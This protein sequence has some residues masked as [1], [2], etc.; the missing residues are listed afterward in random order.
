M[1][2]GYSTTLLGALAASASAHTWVEQL[3]VIAPNG[4]MVGE[5][6]F[7]RGNVRRDTPGFG[8]PA[9]V[10]LIPGNGRTINQILD[11]D[12]ICKDSQ[13]KQVQTNNSPR[14]KAAPGSNVALRYQE[15]GHV[16]LPQG[17]PGKPENRGTVFVYGTTQPKEDDTFLSIH[18]QWNAEGTGGDGRG[19]LLSTRDFD[20]SQCYQVNGGAISVQ[21]QK[22]FAHAATP[23]MGADLWCQQ[24]IQLPASA[25]S[26]KPYTLYWVWDWPTLP[27]TEGFPEG[28]QEI[29]TTCMDIDITAG[30]LGGNGA[31]DNAQKKAAGAVAFVKGQDLANA[32]VAAQVADIAN[33]TAV[34]GDAIPFLGAAASSPGV[35]PTDNSGK[36]SSSLSAP[37]PPPPAPPTPAP[38][39]P[40]APALV[41]SASSQ[42]PPPAPLVSVSKTC[43]QTTG[44][45]SFATETQGVPTSTPA[46][47]QPA[48]QS[49][50]TNRPGRPG[51]DD[52]D[53]AGRP[54]GQQTGRRTATRRLRPDVS[55]ATGAPT[56][57]APSQPVTTDSAGQSAVPDVPGNTGTAI[58]SFQGETT[59]VPISFGASPATAVSSGSAVTGASSSSKSVSDA[60]DDAASTVTQAQT[61]VQTVTQ[62]KMQTMVQSAP[63]KRAV[64]DLP[65]PSI[66]PR[67]AC[68]SDQVNSKTE[69]IYQ[70]RGRAPFYIVPG[71][72]KS[73]SVLRPAKALKP[74]ATSC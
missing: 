33:P 26:G 61:V 24:D 35:A 21:R 56:N 8:D 47:S 45:T 18:R 34:V 38:S 37:P 66:R 68:S 64:T 57:A 58:Q 22:T 1:K 52:N 65:I 16:S 7:P 39:T 41:V 43:S 30:N 53:F 20:D 46:Q 25:P 14:L 54:T 17:Q 72:A 4:T 3:M 42:A 11:T 67:G 70:L 6:G 31:A 13:T 2:Y 40:S 48:D 44:F 32:A 36:L 29:Y 71:G 50:P 23:L 5:P 60:E 74:A 12:L 63:T 27:G 55:S 19:V 62:T 73:S 10:N 15:N 69:S 49:R 51:N 28:K 9:M 59:K